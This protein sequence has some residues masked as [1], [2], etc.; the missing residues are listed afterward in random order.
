MLAV[1]NLSPA[2]ISPEVLGKRATGEVPSTR[3]ED[4][5]WLRGIA[6]ASLRV[7]KL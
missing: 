4:D 3:C 5:G 6:E 7:S 2:A 1:C